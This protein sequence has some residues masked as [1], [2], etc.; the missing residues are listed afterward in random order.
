[1]LVVVRDRVLVVLDYPRFVD[2]RVLHRFDLDA[3]LLLINQQPIV[4]LRLELRALLVRG[5]AHIGPDPPGDPA[6]LVLAQDRARR[7]STLLLLLALFKLAL[8]LLAPDHAPALHVRLLAFFLCEP[9]L[10]RVLGDRLP[11]LALLVGFALL[12]GVLGMV[13]RRVV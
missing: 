10:L 6:V 3:L 11:R 9:G 7:A 12:A 4:F 13:G 8:L 2:P 5:E 1:M